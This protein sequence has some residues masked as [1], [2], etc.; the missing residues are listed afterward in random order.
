MTAQGVFSKLIELEDEPS[1]VEACIVWA[2][3]AMV[4][5]N[6]PAHLITPI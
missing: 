1:T 6:V 2:H 5:K 4:L 3:G